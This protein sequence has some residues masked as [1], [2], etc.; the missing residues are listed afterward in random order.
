MHGE[1]VK[2]RNGLWTFVLRIPVY[3]L[4]AQCLVGR[5]SSSRWRGS[6]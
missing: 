3:I 6:N 1:T 4:S 5:C 2:K